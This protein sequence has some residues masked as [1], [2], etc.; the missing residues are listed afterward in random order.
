MMASLRSSTKFEA[1][2]DGTIQAEIGST[3]WSNTQLE[4]NI[5]ELVKAIHAIK[6]PKSDGKIRS[7]S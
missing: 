3:E 2:E 4:A 1:D 5:K 7:F 6:P